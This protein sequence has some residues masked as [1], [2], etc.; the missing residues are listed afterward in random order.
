MTR[1]QQGITIQ[2]KIRIY[3]RVQ[4]VGFRYSARNQA[5]SLG[6]KGWVENRPDGSV[7]SVIQGSREDCLKYM[8]W[9]RKGSGYS[10]VEKV[11]IKEMEPELL[12]SFRV[13]H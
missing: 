12:T 4:G 2:Y 8:E 3:G 9:C 10:W 11:D 6:L 13:R 7:C 1:K 5:R